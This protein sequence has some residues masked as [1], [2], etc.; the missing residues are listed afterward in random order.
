MRVGFIGR[1]FPLFLK[2]IPGKVRKGREES[3]LPEGKGVSAGLSERF[4][5]LMVGSSSMLFLYLLSMSLNLVPT[6]F[7]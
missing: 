2:G 5:N 6:H 1:R 3:A 4:V 7:R